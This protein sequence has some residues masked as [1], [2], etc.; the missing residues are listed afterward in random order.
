MS[1]PTY[2]PQICKCRHLIDCHVINGKLECCMHQDESDN[3]DCDCDYYIEEG[4]K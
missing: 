1:L 4:T 3:F 2:R